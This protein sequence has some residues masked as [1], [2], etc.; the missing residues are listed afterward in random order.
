MSPSADASN[1][2]TGFKRVGSIWNVIFPRC[3]FV[4]HVRRARW[5]FRRIL[6]RRGAEESERHVRAS[7]CSDEGHV[8]LIWHRLVLPEVWYFPLVWYPF[9][10]PIGRG[11][12]SRAVSSTGILDAA[13]TLAAPPYAKRAREAY[14]RGARRLNLAASLSR[15]ARAIHVLEKKPVTFTRD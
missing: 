9:C 10:V 6:V 7:C 1:W 8:I 14:E 13:P 3:Q 15:L 2:W 5:R 11:V 4:H 12:E